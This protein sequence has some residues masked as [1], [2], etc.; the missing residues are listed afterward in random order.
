MADYAHLCYLSE[1]YD[2]YIFSEQQPASDNVNM[3]IINIYKIIEM[4]YYVKNK[5]KSYK[6]EEEHEYYEDVL[7]EYIS[8]F[9]IS[10][11]QQKNRCYR[12]ANQQI[13]KKFSENIEKFNLM[14]PQ[15]Q[16][17]LVF[18]NHVTTRLGI[19]K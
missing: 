14:S 13:Y 9:W 17:V 18:M 15:K 4:S 7:I 3:R 10:G 11:Q 16:G 12:Q 8:L 5:G 6:I 2:F 1:L 19:R